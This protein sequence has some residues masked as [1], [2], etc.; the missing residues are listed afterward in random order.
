MITDQQSS[1]NRKLFEYVQERE[2]NLAGASSVTHTELQALSVTDGQFRRS[3]WLRTID[4]AFE[5]N[6]V[7]HSA[8]SVCNTYSSDSVIHTAS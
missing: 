8:H 7:T 3:L 4:E 6:M 1:D 5:C 2:R